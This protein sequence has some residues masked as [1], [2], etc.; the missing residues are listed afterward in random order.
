[1]RIT[2]ATTDEELSDF[3]RGRRRGQFR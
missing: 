3:I 1:L 2:D